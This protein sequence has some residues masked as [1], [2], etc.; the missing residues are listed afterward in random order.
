VYTLHE[1]DLVPVVY[2]TTIVYIGRDK[3]IQNCAKIKDLLFSLFSFFYG[4]KERFLFDHGK[5]ISLSLLLPQS[6]V[7]SANLPLRPA[8]ATFR[9]SL[10]LY[11]HTNF[12]Y[13]V[14]ILINFVVAIIIILFT[15]RSGAPSY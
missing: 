4:K 13:Y 15:A 3:N 8:H 6:K 14:L 5:S 9:H 2:T 7:A 10:H 12:A 11:S 1:V